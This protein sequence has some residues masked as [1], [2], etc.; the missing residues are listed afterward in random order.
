LVDS[1][2]HVQAAVSPGRRG[3]SALLV[4]LLAAVI[5]P[6]V[7]PCLQAG[8]E[9]LPASP[10]PPTEKSVG[11]LPPPPDIAG[12]DLEDLSAAER[13]SLLR[14]VQEYRQLIGLLRD[15]LVADLR[16]GD[17]TSL[18]NK[19][20][21]DKA[22]EELGGAI[23]HLSRE[24]SDL[25]VDIDDQ[26]F[27]LHDGSGEGIRISIP[28][29]LGDQ[30]SRG[31]SSITQAILAELPD[32]VT[33]APPAV[34]QSESRS[35]QRFFERPSRPQPRRVRK[36]SAVKLWDDLVV[37]PDEEIQGA[38]V[39]IFGDAIVSG[40]VLGDVVT[41]FG[42]AE[43]TDTAEVDGQVVV[44]G[45]LGQAE[46]S[47]VDGDV[48][49]MRVPSLLRGAGGL[50][51]LFSVGWLSFAARLVEY[52]LVAL[53]VLL[54]LF[55]LPV[56]RREMVQEALTTQPAASLGYGIGTAL[57]GHLL[58][59]IVAGVLILTVVGIP[60]AVLLLL[61]WVAIGLVALA[62]VA[63]EV[64]RRACGMLHLHWQQEWVLALFGLFWLHLLSFLA[65]LVGLWSGLG[66]LATFIGLLGVAIKLLAYCFGIGAILLSRLGTREP[67]APAGSPLPVTE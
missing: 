52:L 41:I 50:E 22:L 19:E 6:A 8:S 35:W 64:G 63:I 57:L 51:G 31:I 25:E 21:L 29:D 58:L 43:L 11:E 39:A 13:D 4:I 27:S 32:T 17:L 16:Q 10:S 18:R 66:A 30:L 37:Q 38:A 23:S 67:T 12:T 55:I 45:R 56:R 5:L 62:A 24:L 47:R 40:H 49:V 14:E 61:A 59:L 3:R 36:G 34:G 65:S 2:P 53:L 60:V 48:V 9:P 42:D 7:P 54:V 20:V 1:I 15:S 28:P 26:T 46:T 33:L 44:L